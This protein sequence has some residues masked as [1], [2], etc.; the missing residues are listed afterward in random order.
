M[1]VTGASGEGPEGVIR[2]GAIPAAVD[3]WDTMANATEPPV[4]ERTA[5][6]VADMDRLIKQVQRTMH[7][8]AVDI[9]PA[10]CWR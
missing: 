6:E 3:G 2:A 9:C 10:R 4:I 8:P 1:A 7:R 5:G